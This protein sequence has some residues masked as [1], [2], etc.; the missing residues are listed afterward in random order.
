MG[1]AN[2]MEQPE[3]ATSHQESQTKMWFIFPH[4]VEKV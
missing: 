3:G 4:G 1:E 2:S